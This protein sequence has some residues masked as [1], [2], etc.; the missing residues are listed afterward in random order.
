MFGIAGDIILMAIGSICIGA[1]I[2]S[3]FI[4]VGVWFIVLALYPPNGHPK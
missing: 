1:A 2:D 4:G 3:W